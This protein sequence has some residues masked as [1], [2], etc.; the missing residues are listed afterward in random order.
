V[1]ALR[2]VPA[3]A[4]ACASIAFLN[5]V[6]WSIITPPFQ[7]RDEPSHFAYV[8]QLAENHALPERESPGY[9]PQ[10]N[11][12][13]LGLHQN[14]VRFSPQT[15]S[16]SSIAEQ[17]A[18][19]TDVHAG[20]S[21]EG[22]GG[23]G[24]A[25]AEPP[26]YYALQTVPYG[27]AEGNMLTQLQLMRLFSALLGG[28][29]ALLIFLFLRELLPGVPWAAAVGALCVAVQPLF[30]YMSGVLNP[31][32]MLYAVSAALFLCLARAFRRGLTRRLSI[33]TGLLI[34]VGFMTKLNFAGVAFGVFAGLLLLG[35]RAARSRRLQELGPLAI[36][37]GV[38]AAPVMLYALVN[39]LSGRQAL[40]FSSD[41]ATSATTGSIYHE[42]SYIWQLYL[43]RLPGMTHYFTGLSM[44]RDIWFNRFVGAYGWVDTMFP[45]WVN[46]IALIPAG[47]IVL[48]C[49]RA[50]IVRRQAL[51]ARLSELTVYAAIGCGVLVMVG[52]MS[53]VA[54][55]GPKL[56]G[57]GDPRYL[58]P[59]LPL[60]GAVVT[61]AVRGAGRR[62]GPVIGAVLVVMFL[63][64]DFFSQL[65]VIA[66][67]YG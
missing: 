13:L 58:L 45:R 20:A 62:W 37:A 19:M 22:P 35:V 4:W 52:I 61:L 16:I 39:V 57:Y 25:S 7:G 42:A 43:P 46:T 41:I 63:A 55:A 65:Q 67:Y 44:S 10:E 23:A 59:M 30:G 17:R 15:P 48:L 33:A 29:T 24:V 53:Y 27:I 18:L 47:A 34:V 3:V 49:G 6:A 1:R 31:D 11:L 60:L 9:S 32:V 28:A 38:G 64:H 26:L 51:R 5:G 66:R 2:G 8:Q 21:A 12:V 40:G 56:E 14:E 54:Y 50:L 36:A